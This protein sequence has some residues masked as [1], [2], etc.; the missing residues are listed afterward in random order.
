MKV[1]FGPQYGG[2]A[3]GEQLEMSVNGERVK[4]IDLRSVPYYYIRGGRGGGRGGAAA[5][6]AGEGPALPFPSKSGCR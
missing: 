3:K 5:G 6:R 4:L 1:N 2:A